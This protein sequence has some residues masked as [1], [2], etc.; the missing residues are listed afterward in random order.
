MDKRQKVYEL[1][2]DERN[3]QDETAE[4]WNHKGVPSLEAELLMLEEYILKTR[5][6]W[7]GSS[8]KS[9]MLKELRKVL[10]IGVRAFENHTIDPLEYKREK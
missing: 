10:A 9:L 2:D 1:I 4:K 3:F 5:S 6:Q 7:C 8:D